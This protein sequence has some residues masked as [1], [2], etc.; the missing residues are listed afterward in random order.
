MVLFEGIDG[1]NSEIS[2]LSSH[3]NLH[4]LPAQLFVPLAVHRPSTS[5]LRTK[6]L[7]VCI[8]ALHLIVFSLSLATDPLNPNPLGIW[9]CKLLLVQF[10]TIRL[11]NLFFFCW[12][13]ESLMGIS[14]AVHLGAQVY[15]LLKFFI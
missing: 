4:L 12:I 15:L 9:L 14:K 6:N 3:V 2:S 10:V 7:Q 13:L 5:S 8:M 11:N 1:R